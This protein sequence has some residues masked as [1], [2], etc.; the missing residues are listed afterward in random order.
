MAI[1]SGF[2]NSL[3]K[4]D[5][6]DK[7]Y[8]SGQMSS[9][10]DGLI[11]DGIYLSTRDDDPANQQFMVTALDTPS[12][13]VSVA[14][15]RAWFKGIY[16]ISNSSMT[17]EIESANTS[18]RIDAVVLELNTKRENYDAG[19]GPHGD[20][21]TERT[22]NLK[23]IKGTPAA[24]PEKPTMVH[25]D[26]ID[27]YP[28]AYVAVDANVTAIKPYDISYVVGIETPYFAWLGEKLSIAE[29]YSKWKPILG[30]MTLPFVAWFASM[31]NML[32]DGNSDYG[33]MLDELS[34][35]NDE[36]Y[37]KGVLPKVDEQSAVFD[38]DG[39]TKN[40]T[41][42]L[43]SGQTINNIADILVDGDVEYGFTFNSSTNTVT[44]NTAPSSGTENIVIYYVLVSESY[45]LYFEEV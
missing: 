10:F 25:A 13:N 24:T 3:F 23:V 27:Q 40:F 39:S 45:T 44:F 5:E 18:D 19:S 12:M 42:T 37:I 41:I 17:L 6:Y 20:V 43:S 15:G 30:Y 21:F 9:L 2:Y 11:L 38:G 22:V 16:A 8:D 4:N 34:D 28:I 14:S 36:D 29:L 26:G 33:N 31:Q 7:R 1:K 35:V 32:G